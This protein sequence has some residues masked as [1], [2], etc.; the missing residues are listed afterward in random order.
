[1]DGMPAAGQNNCNLRSNLV[2]LFNVSD[3]ESVDLQNPG[4][5]CQKKKK[6]LD[7]NLRNQT[8]WETR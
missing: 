4:G 7:D 5:S 1:M 6:E 2:T 8:F 3:F